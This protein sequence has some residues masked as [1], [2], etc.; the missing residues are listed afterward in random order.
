MFTI[1]I[2]WL[3]LNQ[4]FMFSTIKWERWGQLFLRARNTPENSNL[5]EMFR[6]KES[7]HC[8][9]RFSHHPGRENVWVLT[10]L[11]LFSPARAPASPRYIHSEHPGKW[12]PAPLKQRLLGGGHGLTRSALPF[13]WSLLALLSFSHS[14]LMSTWENLQRAI[15]TYQEVLKL[16]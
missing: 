16:F 7:Q 13:W 2:V 10:C 5:E 1:W 4:I 9:G 12:W 3:F 11:P 6:W 15:R 14:S 8:P